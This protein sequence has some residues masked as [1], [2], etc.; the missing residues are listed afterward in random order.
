M[1]D[2]ARLQLQPL[3]P[4]LAFVSGS[5]HSASSSYCAQHPLPQLPSICSVGGEST[6]L[7]TFMEEKTGA[8]GKQLDR[9]HE[10][11]KWQKQEP[12]PVCQGSSLMLL[13]LCGSIPCYDGFLK[14]HLSFAFHLM[15]IFAFELIIYI[16][17]VLFVLMD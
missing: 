2:S 11:W 17:Y 5:C 6:G 15:C 14:F 10:A 16:V 12:S 3:L 7:T 9:S 1:K 4:S 13:P 8:A